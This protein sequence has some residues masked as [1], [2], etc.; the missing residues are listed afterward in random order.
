MTTRSKTEALNTMAKQGEAASTSVPISLPSSSASVPVHK[1]N[2]TYDGSSSVRD[3]IERVEELAQ[4]RNV[5]TALLF[6]SAVE[7]FA[8]DAL[9]WF[10]VNRSSFSSWTELVVALKEEFELLDHER[11]LLAQLRS[12][13]Q[14]QKENLSTFITRILVLNN[15]LSSKLPEGELLE[16][17]Q[18]NMLP[19]YIQKLSLSVIPDIVTLKKLGKM[20]ELADSRSED[21]NSPG[22]S[23]PRNSRDFR[24]NN[25]AQNNV[26]Q[27]N[28]ARRRDNYNS[29]YVNSNAKKNRYSNYDNLS[30]SRK[31]FREVRCFRCGRP[32]VKA[33]ACGCRGQS[34]N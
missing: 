2:I 22:S 20:I 3:F 6:S 34:K 5:S 15:R 21:R 17:L 10:R 4:A 1:W 13:L 11:R 9:S 26:A 28:V 7:L 25:V 33:P 19:R 23:Q 8:G 14:L 18:C 32:G 27:N 24:H 31:N 30:P 12:T 16:I 29:G